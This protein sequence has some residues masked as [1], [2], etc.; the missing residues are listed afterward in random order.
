[1]LRVANVLS[2]IGVD[3]GVIHFASSEIVKLNRQ[4]LGRIL[5][6]SMTL[7]MLSGAL[8]G[9][10]LCVAA[11]ALAHRVFHKGSVLPTIYV[12]AAGVPLAAGLRV[13]SASTTVSQ[14]MKY[15]VYAESIA[16]PGTNLLLIV[17]F[18]LVG[19]RLLGAV[20]A[21]VISFGAALAVALHYE[22]KLFPEFQYLGGRRSLAAGRELLKFSLVAWLASVFLNVMPWI[23]RLFVGA[24]LPATEV[25]V[26]QAAAQTSVLLSVIAGALNAVVSPRISSLHHSSQRERLHQVYKVATKWMVYTS[27]PILLL[28]CSV[29]KQVLTLLYGGSYVNG[30]R[31]LIILSIMWMI[32][33]MAGPVGILLI[34]TGRQKVVSI[35][36]AAGMSLCIGLNYLFVPGYG[37]VGAAMATGLTN[38]AMMLALLL[39]ARIMVGVWPFDKRWTKGALATGASV[40]ALVLAAHVH[41]QP[42]LPSVLFRLALSTTAFVGGLL[43]L[44]LDLEDREMLRVLKHYLVALTR[45][46]RTNVA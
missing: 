37:A 12:F 45:A 29:P 43:L 38:S 21:T 15:S 32:D 35:V 22:R 10:A 20:L 40:G 23:D 42:V 6:E 17:V 19:W 4:R 16:Q 14:S 41:V 39:A 1:M 44:G 8:V 11:P 24:Y 5:V 26:Y 27:V 31:P 34:F 7:A 28:F 33:A 3:S 30:S 13:A 46:A 18:Y 2:P 36:A 9:L 25:G